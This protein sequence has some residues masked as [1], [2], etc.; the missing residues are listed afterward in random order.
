MVDEA[1]I[2]AW[3]DHPSPK[4][5]PPGWE[6]HPDTSIQITAFCGQACVGAHL[7]GA[8]HPDVVEYCWLLFSFYPD[9]HR[10][11]TLPQ[12][13]CPVCERHRP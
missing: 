13:S 6:G 10:G 8:D 2:Q 11:A 9:A 7:R 12:G 4:P 3:I 5:P 1:V